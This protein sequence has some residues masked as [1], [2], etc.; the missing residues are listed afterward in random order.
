M[1]FCTACGSYE[2]EIPN[3]YGPDDYPDPVDSLCTDCFHCLPVLV[4]LACPCGAGCF[5]D[6][7]GEYSMETQRTTITDE[8]PMECGECGVEREAEE[9]QIVEIYSPGLDECL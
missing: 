7:E 6:V 2:P 9:C 8:F 5:Q 3:A 4:E 1:S